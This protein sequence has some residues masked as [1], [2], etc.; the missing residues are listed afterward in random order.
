M[1]PSL[2]PM[3]KAELNKLFFARIIFPIWHTQWV[4]NLVSVRKKNGDMLLCMDFHNLNKS[5]DKDGYL[6]PS[7]E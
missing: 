3:V 2:E 5:L 1:H 7:M 6:V 4:E